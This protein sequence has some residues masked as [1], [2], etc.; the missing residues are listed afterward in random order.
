ART[1]AAV[2][3]SCEGESLSYAELE[4]RSNR[5]AHHLRALGVGPEVRVGVRMERGVQMVVALLGTLRAGGAY[6]P[7]DPSY[8]AD[9]T[10]Y[11]LADSG[12]AVL[13]TEARPGGVPDAGGARVVCLDGDREEI[14][15]R[16]GEAPPVE[17]APDNLAYVIYTS[18]STGRTKGAMNAHRGVVNRLLWMQEAYGLGP[19]DVVLQKTPYGFDVSVWE[20]FW[21]L[22][23]GAR[24]VLARPEG[25]R[26]AAYLAD[27]IESEGVTTLHFVPSMLGAFLEE[28]ELPRRCRSVRRVVCSGEALP[29][30]LADRFH[31]RMNARAELH[32]LYGPTEAAVD[33]TAWACER[34]D[35]RRSVPIGRPVANTRIYLLDSRMDPVPLGVAG[36]LYIGGVQVGRGYLDRPALTAERFLPDPYAFGAGERMYRTG[37]LARSRVG[38]EIEYLGRLDH[39]V[40]IRGFRIELGEVESVLQAHPGVREAVVLAREDVPGQ[41]RLVGYVVGEEADAPGADELR[42]FLA[43]TLP[44]YMV[45]ASFVALP[46]LPLSPNGKVDRGALPPAE[47]GGTA[48]EDSALRTPTEEMLAGIWA[49]VLRVRHVGV[50]DNFFI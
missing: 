25:H 46:A 39:Q 41:Q 40:K 36:E 13:L 14:G 3:V 21:P 5:L 47:A 20:F 22:L 4:R 42:A 45:P 27:L 32:N 19:D 50:H 9:R 29:A 49:E 44:E 28:P 48:G 15:R 16:P 12:V 17:V 34:G 2:A 10:A 43:A 1:P 24:M 38:G 30:E 35:P 11:V 6:V 37:D 8:P 31:A 18:G 23:A 33:V 7:I 26:D